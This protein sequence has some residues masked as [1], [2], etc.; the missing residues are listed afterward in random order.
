MKSILRTAASFLTVG[1]LSAG[2]AAQ[3]AS[4]RYDTDIQTRVTQ[5]LAKKSEFRNLQASTEDG[6][7]TLSG[8]VDLYQ[9]KLDAGKKV[10]KLDKVQGVRNQ[11]AVSTTT[12]DAQLAAKLERKLHYD[13]IGYDNEFNFVN[14]AVNNG[15]A[16]LNGETRTD[17]GRDSA[18][19]LVNNMPG[20]KQVV[21]NIKVS[22]VSGF[23]DRIRISAMRAIY[24]DP[25]LSRYASDPAKPIRIVVD[26]G[27][28][29]LYGTVESK[30]D[31][32]IAGIRAGGVFGVFQVQNNLVV[33]KS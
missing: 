31:K 30:M 12:P 15:V 24:R 4:A 7:V 3:T 23:D 6:I 2:L 13:R 22:P 18:L 5:Q 21:D 26:N 20:V 25:V 9:Q 33:A 14:V 16:T 32:D 10:R 27:K 8:S 29:S 19:S 1:I 28:L 17:V 11:V